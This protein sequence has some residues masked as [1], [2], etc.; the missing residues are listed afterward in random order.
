MS[1]TAVSD[2]LEKSGGYA[3]EGI[4]SDLVAGKGKEIL[5]KLENL[6]VTGADFGVLREKWIEYFQAKLLSF[7][8]VGEKNPEGMDM[9]AATKWLSLLIEAGMKEKLTELSQLPLQ[10]AV[11]EF[12]GQKFVKS[13][14][15]KPEIKTEKNII[16]EEKPKITKKSGGKVSAEEIEKKWS[17][18]LAVVKPYNH[19]V[20]AF[21]RATRPG[22]IRDGVLVLEVFYK[23]HKERLEEAKNRKIVNAG[24]AVALG[25]EIEFECVLAEG[26]RKSPVKEE[27]SDIA[28]KI[29]N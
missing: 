8:G 21:L 25:E 18:V 16:D 19:S 11:V 13:E 27:I 7:Y 3:G 23:F 26:G 9:V 24:L 17:E 22:K 12:L 14:S 10:L 15:L 28:E 29:F 6:A 5:G 20:E 4:E 1:L 2:F